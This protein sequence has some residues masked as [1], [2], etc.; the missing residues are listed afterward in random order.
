MTSIIIRFATLT[1]PHRS[2]E[3]LVTPATVRAVAALWQGQP[4]AAG[5]NRYSTASRMKPMGDALGF[6]STVAAAFPCN[7]TLAD[8]LF[9][10]DGSS[11]IAW[12]IAL[13]DRWADIHCAAH[14]AE[15]ALPGL[16]AGLP[17][18]CDRVW[19]SVPHAESMGFLSSVEIF[20]LAAVS[21]MAF[22]DVGRFSAIAV[23]DLV[24][25]AAAVHTTEHRIVARLNQPGAGGPRVTLHAE[26]ML[27]DWL[28]PGQTPESAWRR[29]LDWLAREAMA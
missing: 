28:L 11:G 14:V 12:T 4:L 26:R 20:D 3:T 10:R 6:A 19:R 25:P 27:L 22:P 8:S 21:T 24:D 29:R 2:A 1:H 15:A 16:V 9:K 7:L 5:I 17:A 23:A 13:R 18:L